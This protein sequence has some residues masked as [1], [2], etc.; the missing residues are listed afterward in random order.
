MISPKEQIYERATNF[1]VDEQLLVAI[2][3]GINAEMEPPEDT[4]E[5]EG[6]GM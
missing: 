4:T 1:D 3:P 6:V 5:V 2:D